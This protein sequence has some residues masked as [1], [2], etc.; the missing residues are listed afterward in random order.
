MKQL[1]SKL[2]LLLFLLTSSFYA[3]AQ[4]TV[5]IVANP[6]DT[7]CEGSLVR[8]R[9]F[10]DSI[11]VFPP[12]PPDTTHQYIWYVNGV[13][14]GTPGVMYPSSTLA[15]GDVV[16]CV[17]LN[18][19]GDTVIDTSN[20]IT[21]TVYPSIH[22]GP[23]VGP[24]SVCLGS[25]ITLS[26]SVT[27]GVWHS[28]N[29][30][31]FTIDPST[32]VLTTVAPGVTRA[33]YTTSNGI[34]S[35]SVR[36]RIRVQVPGGPIIGPTTVCIDSM[37]RLTDTARGGQWSVSDST[38]ANLVAPFGLFGALSAGTVNVYYHVDNACGIFDDTLAVS[39]INCDT[40]ASVNNVTTTLNGLYIYPNPNDGNFCI[41]F[42]STTETSGILY[43]T[44][45]T[46]RS[47]LNKSIFSN[48]TF[49]DVPKLSSGMYFITI[50]TPTNIYTEK[51]IIK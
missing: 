12:P 13:A 50:H 9:A 47:M 8:F 26:D 45:V 3:N 30:S 41:S 33:V 43:I 6:G 18:A 10:G 35:D 22:P 29:T 20:Y 16:Y 39:I 49:T 36:L 11:V 27:G 31:V 48:T 23:I 5:A 14:S 34:C 46:G 15:N 7:I 42:N 19:T 40:V 2:L 25:S 4:T 21:M 24:D 32:G 1:Y 28:N 38:I 37:F 44:D 51:L 17:M